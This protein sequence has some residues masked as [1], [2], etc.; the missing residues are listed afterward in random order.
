MERI[1]KL[2]NFHIVL[3]LLKDTCWVMDLKLPGMIM[4]IPTLSLAL[5]ITWRFRDLRSEL[6]HNLAVCC[7]IAANSVWMT[8]EF[9]YSDTTRHLALIFFIAGFMFIG[10]YYMT[11]ITTKKNRLKSTS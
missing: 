5:Y 9:Y 2:E 7:W 8:G 4:I 3:W 10:W 1:R 6:Y 11:Q